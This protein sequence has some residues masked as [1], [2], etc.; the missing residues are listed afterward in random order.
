MIFPVF[1]LYPQHATSDTISDF[2]EDTRFHEH[3]ALMFPPQGGIPPWDSAGEYRTDNLVVY[4]ITR[5][6]RLL[7]VGKKMTLAD[8]FLASAGKDGISD[9]LELKQGYLSFVIVPKG[10]QEAR[11]IEEV[12]SSR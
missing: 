5:R 12:K 2:H 9:G 11:W 1:F 7:K 8:V 10:E 4:A 6:K 3:L